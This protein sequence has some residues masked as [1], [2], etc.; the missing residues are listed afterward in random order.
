MSR[1]ADALESGLKL[2]FW[3]DRA[4]CGSQNNGEYTVSEAD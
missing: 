3:Q 2:E 4:R 1:R